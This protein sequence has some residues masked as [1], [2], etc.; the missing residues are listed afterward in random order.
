[1][2]KNSSNNEP[3][4]EPRTEPTITPVWVEWEEKPLAGTDE[5]VEDG[6]LDDGADVEMREVVEGEDEVRVEGRV[7]DKVD[8]SADVEGVAEVEGVGEGVAGIEVVADDAAGDDDPPKTQTPSVPR[9][10]W[11]QGKGF[12]REVAQHK[13]E[14]KLVQRAPNVRLRGAK[15]PDR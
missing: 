11:R 8:D 13:E 15:L 2:N 1:M 5:V 10:I 6:G 7:E 4:T 3:R 14:V 12:S 9:G